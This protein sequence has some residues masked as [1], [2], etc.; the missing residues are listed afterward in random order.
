M[1][2]SFEQMCHLSGYGVGIW[3]KKWL[4]ELEE[5]QH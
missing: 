3:R 2:L 1:E 5:R 4:L